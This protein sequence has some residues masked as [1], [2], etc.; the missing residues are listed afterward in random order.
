MDYDFDGLCCDQ[1]ERLVKRLES[2]NKQFMK[3]Y[4]LSMNVINDPEINNRREE[5]ISNVKEILLAHVSRIEVMYQGAFNG[6][7]KSIEG[8]K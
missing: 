4:V 1:R 6:V 2:I 3:E 5:I 7:K 8:K